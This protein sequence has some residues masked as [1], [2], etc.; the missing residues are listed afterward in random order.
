MMVYRF[1]NTQYKDDISG[2]GSRLFG[3]RWNYKGTPALYASGSISLALLE[4][5]VNAKSLET[6]K[7]LA[8]LTLKIPEELHSSVH[9]LSNLKK[10]WMLDYEYCKYIGTHFLAEKKFLFLQCPSAVIGQEWN[11]VI[12]PLHA[13][14][15]NLSIVSADDYLFDERLFKKQ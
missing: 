11:F 4:I 14:F 6:V 13:E 8:L 5:L 10:E 3:G 2:T 1:S 7:S 12:N 15:N 9:V